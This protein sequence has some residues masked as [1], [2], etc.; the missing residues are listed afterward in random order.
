MNELRASKKNI[1]EVK[2][3]VINWFNTN[4]SE[5]KH[6]KRKINNDINIEKFS[7]NQNYN[8]IISL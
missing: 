4:S 2:K 5:I 6:N 7:A 1:K 8:K 3:E